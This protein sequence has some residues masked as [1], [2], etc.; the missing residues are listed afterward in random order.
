[1]LGYYENDRLVYAGRVGT[2][3]TRQMIS[4]V[5]AELKSRRIDAPPFDSLPA[6]VAACGINWVRP[7]LVCEVAFTQWTGDGLLRHPSFK[8]LREDKCPQ[9]VVREVA[10]PDP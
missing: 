2:G 6:D 3:F 10:S 1:M 4:E 8:N 7:E 9:Q 5:M